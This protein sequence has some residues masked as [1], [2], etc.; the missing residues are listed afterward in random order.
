MIKTLNLVCGMSQLLI[1][2]IAKY[3]EKQQ[4]FEGY[5]VIL[6]EKGGEVGQREG[7]AAENYHIAAAIGQ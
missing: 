6:Q 3:V 1:I 2:L 4:R 5:Y 7:N